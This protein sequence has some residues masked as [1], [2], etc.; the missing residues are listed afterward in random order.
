M[1]KL[2]RR[3]R[4][5]AELEQANSSRTDSAPEKVTAAEQTE[6]PLRKK[7]QGVGLRNW[8]KQTAATRTVPRESYGCGADRTSSAEKGTGSGAAELE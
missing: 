1:R 6:L 4:I 3:S 5:K 7:A 2:R 8:N